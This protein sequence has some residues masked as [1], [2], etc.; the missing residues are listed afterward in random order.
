MATFGERLRELRIEKDMNVTHLAGYLGV[1]RRLISFY[2]N[3]EREPGHEAI[4][5]L[6]SLFGCT[7]D[8]L[9]GLSDDRHGVDSTAA[10]RIKLIEMYDKL[11]QGKQKILDD[12]AE[13]LLKEMNKD[14]R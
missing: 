12:L 5:K 10:Q 7:A 3:D 1:S 11:P 6:C 4:K 2:E 8:Y 13:V 9:L 14:P